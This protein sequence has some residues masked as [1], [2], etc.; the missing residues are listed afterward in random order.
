MN[1]LP[2]TLI[3]MLAATPAAAAAPLRVVALESPAPAGSAEPSL[4]ARGP[5]LHLTWLEEAPEGGS[6]LRTATLANGRWSTPATIASGKTLLANWADFPSLLPLADDSLVAHWLERT[7]AEGEAY[8]IRVAR[9]RDG[10]KAWSPPAT[11]HRDGTQ[12]EHGFVSL[13]D[14]GAGAT[15]VVW[16][17]GRE[18]AQA[19]SLGVGGGKTALRAAIL[20]AGSFGDETVLDP[21]VCDC[22]QTSAASTPRGAFV[23]YRDRSK[24]EVRDISYVRLVAGRWTEPRALHDDGW[25]IG[26]CPVNGPAVAARGDRLAVGWFTAA[27]PRATGVAAQASAGGSRVLLA[28]SQDGGESFSPAVRV[29]AGNPA[30]RVDVEWLDEDT[31]VAVWNERGEGERAELRA[32]AIDVSGRLE[33][34]VTVAPVSAGRGS[35][36]PRLAPYADGVAVAWTDAADRPRVRLAT[37]TRSGTEASVPRA[38]PAPSEPMPLPPL[39]NRPAPQFKGRALDGKPVALVDLRGKVVLL[40]FWGIWCPPCREEI[41]EL[42]R[43]HRD[44]HEKGLEIVA[45]N[46]G[47]PKARLTTF[48]AEQK[49]PYT[50]LVQDNLPHRYRVASFPTSVIIDQHGQ[51]RYVAEGYSSRAIPDMRRIVEHLLEGG[52]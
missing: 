34:D 27:K 2:G 14:A 17:D 51:V 1:L 44:L 15:L 31:V 20:D 8:D 43:L 38:A 47:D 50:I 26:A 13:V 32:R 16:L 21:L 40:N 28:V 41:P 10:G 9:S 5:S 12:A 19:A 3:A 25:E 33:A 39:E 49:I 42:A 6:R 7:A 22:C 36:F 48:V 45:V 29:D 11:P 35:G 18:Y 52:E 4:A 23:A 24:T 30:G 46:V 37:L